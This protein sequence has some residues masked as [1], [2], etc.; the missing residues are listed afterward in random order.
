KIDFLKDVPLN[1]DR[2]VKF[3]SLT[4]GIYG[5][6]HAWVFPPGEVWDHYRTPGAM[7][8]LWFANT[9]YLTAENASWLLRFLADMSINQPIN[10]PLAAKMQDIL[11]GT[12]N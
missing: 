1:S 12:L 4:S 6:T 7:P 11:G 10:A 2:F 3:A 5:A 8:Q 9:A